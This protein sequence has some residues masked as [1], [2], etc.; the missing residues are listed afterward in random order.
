MSLS[1][2]PRYFLAT[3]FASLLAL[4]CAGQRAPEGGPVDTDPPVI[5]STYPQNYSTRYTGQSIVLEFDE[6][7]DHRSVEGAIFISPSVGTLEFDW[8]GREVEIRFSES[9]RQNTTYVVNIGTDVADLRNRNKMAQSFALAFSTGDQIDRGVIEGKIYTIRSSDSP[10]GVMIFAYGLTGVNPDTLN[11][12]HARPDYATQSGKG[13]EFSLRHLALG[14]YRLIAIRDEYKNLL[15]DPETDEFGVPPFG[16]TLTEMDT[17][18]TD[19]L[20]QLARADTTAPRLLKV[21]APDRRHVLAEFSEPLDTTAAAWPV[22]EIVD[23]LGQEQLVIRSV[24][25][26]LPTHTTILIVTDAQ[27]PG[28]RYRLTVDSVRDLHGLAVSPL[29]NSLTFSGSAAED[30]LGPSIASASVA[31]SAVGVALLPELVVHFSD[32]IE[33]TK[34][35]GAIV[36]FDSSE[37]DVTAFPRW[38]SDCSFSLEPATKLRSKEWY[39]LVIDLGKLRDIVGNEGRDTTVVLRFQTVDA[40]LFSNI[41]GDAKDLRDTDRIGPIILQAENV[42]RKDSKP[43]LVVV[44][45]TGKFALTEMPEGLYVLRLFRDRNQNLKYDAGAPFP[46]EPSE[47]FTYYPDTLKVRARW[48]LEGVQLILR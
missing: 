45:E 47:R 39:R 40:E 38:L 25:V 29:A 48:P 10:S 6:Y 2:V 3:V 17:I 27:R 37:K 9:L 14:D 31:D 30:T 22:A 7:V 19:V 42:S 16:I 13:G 28:E 44:H 20:I 8:S 46:F 4:S 26:L 5:V 18:Q 41:E 35:S 32:A 1:G 21:T 11:P 12:Q 34:A 33:T 43:Y 24:S 15:Y 23:T 36:L